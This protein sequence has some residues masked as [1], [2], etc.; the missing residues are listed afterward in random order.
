MQQPVIKT[1]PEASLNFKVGFV[2]IRCY[3]SLVHVTSWL[4]YYLLETI[5]S[6]H[7]KTSIH[8]DGKLTTQ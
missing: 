3:V 1:I 8:F 4:C 7:G 6:C 5:N 2:A